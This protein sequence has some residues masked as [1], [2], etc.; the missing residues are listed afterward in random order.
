MN[1]FTVFHANLMFSSIPSDHVDWIIEDCYRP[2]LTFVEEQGIPTGLELSGH[3]LKT[4]NALDPPLVEKIRELYHLGLLEPICGAQHQSIGPLMPA[5]DNFENY[6]AGR[7]TFSEI[8]GIDAGIFYLP[9]QTVSRGVLEIIAQSGYKAVFIE[10]N[11]I[12]RFGQLPLDKDLMGRCP[13]ISSQ[14]GHSLRLLWNHCVL[15][16]KIQRCLFED[17]GQDEVLKY[18]DQE[19]REKQ[20]ALCLYGS[21]LEVFGYF[22][23]KTVSR[24]PDI[25]KKRWRTFKEIVDRLRGQY[26]FIL[27]SRALSENE[28][29]RMVCLGSADQPISCKKQ[30]KYNPVRW[31]VCGRGAWQINRECYGAST[32]I[33]ILSKSGLISKNQEKRLRESLAPCWA[34]DFRTFTTEE[35]WQQA[36]ADVNAAK[37]LVGQ[38]VSD[39]AE[40]C[41]PDP[42][43]ICVLLNPG[44]G[45]PVILEKK[46]HFKPNAVLP[47]ADAYIDSTPLPLQWEDVFVYP[48]GYAR[49]AKIIFRLEAP[50]RG[51]VRIRFSGQRRENIAQKQMLEHF[52]VNDDVRVSINLKRG[53][54]LD[55]VLFKTLSKMPLLGTVAHGYYESIDW[56]ADFYSG[57]AQVD[58]GDRFYHD[59]LPAESVS[60]V[61][62]PLRSVAW[63]TVAMG[64]MTQ[65]KQLMLYTHQPRL[66]IRQSFMVDGLTSA[67]FRIGIITLLPDAWNQRQLA[68][69]C[70]NGGVDPEYYPLAGR[71]VLHSEPVKNGISSRSCLGATNGWTAFSD[72]E[73]TLTISR[74]LMQGYSA[75]LLRY[76]EIGEKFFARIYHSLGERD[77]T[78]L[79]AHRGLIEESFSITAGSGEKIIPSFNDAIFIQ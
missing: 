38:A 62:G 16:Q 9:E 41:N 52:N 70:Q 18:V 54:C 48:D 78:S 33:R 50:A 19:C 14:N 2:L 26:E 31:S 53:F 32:R 77:E 55:A 34:S 23:G 43:E 12:V 24:Q 72:N 42:G 66:D 7:E 74:N 58:A 21:D 36:Y 3:T 28:D 4:L 56:D 47:G 59:L 8:L 39:I 13:R 46:L 27:P 11:N 75:P 69:I 44:E 15:F 17:I 49:S 60:C 5:E 40:K 68:V 45:F 73:K 30:P 10:W 37:M 61:V 35:K 64:A 20:G 65:K 79:F 51:L 63:A 22:P 29:D 25:G 67:S 57:G 1:L 6:A 71:R 76:E